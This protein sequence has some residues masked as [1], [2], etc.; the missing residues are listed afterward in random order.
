MFGFA[1]RRSTPEPKLSDRTRVVGLDLTAS[2]IRGVALAA[3]RTRPLLLADPLEDLPM[4]LSMEQRKPD[5][6]TPGRSLYRRRPHL[7]CS[8]FL[9]A[10]GQQREWQAGRCK[11]TPETA[12]EACLEAVRPTVQSETDAVAVS[13]PTYLSSAQS[14]SVLAIANSAKLPLCGTTTTPL[15]VAAHRAHW[16]LGQHRH[17]DDDESDNGL[18]PFRHERI[19]AAFVVIVDVDEFAL[20][21]S[22]VSISEREVS[23][24]ASASWPHLALKQW[25]DHL[26][27]SIADRCVRMC[28]RDP[29]DLADSEQALYEQIDSALEQIYQG[30][31]ST[32]TIRGA[33]W[34]QDLVHHQDDFDSYCGGLSKQSA[35]AIC[36]LI[37]SARTPTSSRAIWLTHA[38]SRLPGLPQSIYRVAPE[39][40]DVLALPINAV[41]DATATLVPRWLTGQLPGVHLDASIALAEMPA[42]NS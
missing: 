27:D 22:V 36:E 15:A 18:S 39:Q 35:E 4:F 25:K 21:A 42:L 20:T 3:G 13:L 28:R 10:L 26:L 1:L 16:V 14:K 11:L 37:R 32:L 6:G 9:P 34:Y 40:T 29:R 33:H 12:L 5:V 2:R 7:V 30:Q 24:A 41:A 31:S 17:D 8:N 19:G 23:L 38:A